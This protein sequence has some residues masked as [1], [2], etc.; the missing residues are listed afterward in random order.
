M[1]KTIN[2]KFFLFLFKT[3][4]PVKHKLYLQRKAEE[5]KRRIEKE[6]KREEERKN[7]EKFAMVGGTE[8]RDTNNK[9]KIDNIT[10]SLTFYLKKKKGHGTIVVK[11]T[12]F[13][14]VKELYGDKYDF[15]EPM[16][17]EAHDEWNYNGELVRKT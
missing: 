8:L 16:I 13:E 5:E 10:G 1:A 11:G 7:I 12:S 2:N 15:M 3:F 14:S 4:F 17:K 6:K 9:T